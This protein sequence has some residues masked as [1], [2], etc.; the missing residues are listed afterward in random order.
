M[1]G[2]V[3]SRCRPEGSRDRFGGGEV[4]RPRRAR[5]H[6]A[7][8]ADRPNS[9]RVPAAAGGG[10]G[11]ALTSGWLRADTVIPGQTRNGPTLAFSLRQSRYSLLIFLRTTEN[12]GQ[13]T[14]N[15]IGSPPVRSAST[16]ARL[17]DTS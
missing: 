14:E 17:S 7:R 11:P 16:A 12:G 13:V 4:S 3:P 2:S 10:S 8:R 9:E 5:R 1:E 15:G 6:E